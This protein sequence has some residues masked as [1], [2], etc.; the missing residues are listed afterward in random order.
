MDA[1]RCLR[2][3]YYS[4]SQDR[5][6]R[7]LHAMSRIARRLEPE[8]EGIDLPPRPPGMHQSRYDRLCE[9][10]DLQD[11]IWAIAA[12]RRLG[13]VLPRLVRQRRKKRRVM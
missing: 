12:M 6:G 11:N 3:R 13:I 8:G 9:R 5:S 7:A 1:S 2:L 4:Q 10:Y